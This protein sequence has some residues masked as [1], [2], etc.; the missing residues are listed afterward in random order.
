[1]EGNVVGGNKKCKAI[2]LRG[3]YYKLSQEQEVGGFREGIDGYPYLKYLIDFCPGYC[4]KNLSKL[5]E[6]V[7]ERN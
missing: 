6:E 5:N 2:G 3:F 7:D 4:I 1:M